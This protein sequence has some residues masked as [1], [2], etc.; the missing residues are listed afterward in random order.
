M[1]SFFLTLLIC[2]SQPAMVTNASW[3]DHRRM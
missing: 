3:F 2:A 1:K